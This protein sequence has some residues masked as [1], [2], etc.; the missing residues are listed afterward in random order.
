[1]GE[2]QPVVW[3]DKYQRALKESDQEKLLQHIIDAEAAIFQRHQQ[4]NGSP[5]DDLERQKMEE[6]AKDLLAIKIH[7]LNWPSLP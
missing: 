3:E 6:A 4:L 1:M 2:S 7:K 5:G